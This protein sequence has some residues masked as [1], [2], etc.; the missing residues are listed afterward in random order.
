M[1][2]FMMKNIMKKAIMTDDRSTGQGTAHGKRAV[3]CF[4]CKNDITP[5]DN[6]QIKK[7][8]DK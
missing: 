4:F 5:D 3:P 6:L 1:R 7:V 2:N 8:I